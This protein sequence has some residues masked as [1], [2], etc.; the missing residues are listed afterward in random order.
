M[1]RRTLWAMALVLLL[2]VPGSPALGRYYPSIRTAI[3][4]PTRSR[5]RS[6]ERAPTRPTATTMA[7]ATGPTGQTVNV[8]ALPG[9]GPRL[10]DMLVDGPLD[11][12]MHDGFEFW[13][14]DDATDDPNVQASLERANASI[15]PT[16]RL[17]AAPAAYWCRVPDKAHVR[18]VLPRRRGR[19]AGRALPALRRRRA[20]ARR[21]TPSSPACSARTACSSRSGTCPRD[22]GRRTT[23]EAPVAGFA[24]RYADALA[25]DR[26]AGRRRAPRPPGP[27]RPPAHPAVRSRGSGDPTLAAR[28]APAR[29]G[30]TCS[31]GRRG[32][33]PAREPAIRMTSMPARSSWALVSTLRS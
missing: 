8:P 4:Y 26:A 30:R 3:G 25:G 22:A 32:R 12:T 16:V 15:Y 11:I 5:R 21:A 29:S 28:A 24:K 19:R 13:L 17:A 10:Q 27:A 1:S 9:A 14:E 6:W 31:A 20:A 2:M 18:W 23:W 7:S 33:S